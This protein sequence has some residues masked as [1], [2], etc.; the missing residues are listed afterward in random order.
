MR[1]AR[2]IDRRTV[3][4]PDGAFI[5]YSVHGTVGPVLLLIHGWCGGQ[6]LWRFQ[7]KA[8]AEHYRIVAIDLSGHG[9]SPHPPH[10]RAWSIEGFAQDVVDVADALAAEQVVL[11]GHSMGGAVAVEAALR[12][13][14]RCAL[15]LGVDTFTD[16]AFYGLR[17]AAEIAA[18]QQVFATDFAG[19]MAGMVRRITGV[20]VEG[21]TVQWIV[22]TMTDFEPAFALAILGALLAWNIEARWPLLRCPAETINSAMLAAHCEE[23]ELPGL[24]VQFMERVGH[25]PMIEDPDG[26]NALVR[27]TLAR[28][29]LT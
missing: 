5:H 4:T 3:A 28:H 2:S 19:S 18:R 27:G 14:P 13:G 22:D 15:M 23:L 17:P 26:F 11:V 21:R 9:L 29:G 7:A 6:G 16:A 25:F 12:L 24:A 1:L 20:D 8:L 10:T